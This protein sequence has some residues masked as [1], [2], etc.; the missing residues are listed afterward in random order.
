MTPEVELLYRELEDHI[1]AHKVED[2]RRVYRNLLRAGRPA[3]EIISTLH[4]YTLKS[5]LESELEISPNNESPQQAA[6]PELAQ[7]S[8]EL[9]SSDAD[10]AGRSDMPRGGAD[11]TPNLADE[12]E[13]RGAR[14]QTQFSHRSPVRRFAVL[15]SP[16]AQLA[17]I[18]VA[19]TAGGLLL[20][21]PAPEKPAVMAISVLNPP[22]L[23][24]EEASKTLMVPSTLP[25]EHAPEL[26]TTMPAPGEG[27]QTGVAAPDT[28]PAVALPDPA[29]LRETPPIIAASPVAL[30][31][32][33]TPTDPV[34]RK[35]AAPIAAPT[36]VAPTPDTAPA[37][38]M[39][40]PATPPD[41]RRGSTSKISAAEISS[42]LTRGDS[43]F[44]VGDV[45]SARLYYERAADAGDAQAALRLGESYDPSFL[46]WA[47]LN[48]VRGDPVVATRW[49][50]R[51]R[52]LGNPEAEILLKS[53]HAN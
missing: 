20:L 17:I 16:I 45:T 13:P 4:T 18:G 33:T 3:S 14:D 31:P 9:T 24:S 37:V 10:L 53:L 21:H 29:P 1:S 23:P 15:R 34:P 38:A 5:G 49:Y 2:I 51:A 48:G 40:G 19:A 32:D 26:T 28:T 42:L 12:P 52:E 7:N 47:R 50:R 41:E 22:P 11:D 6:P 36:P 25:P 44:G 27:L 30:A 43:L 39:I 8:S 46:A 35:E